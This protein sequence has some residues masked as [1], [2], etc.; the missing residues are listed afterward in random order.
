MA[1]ETGLG[2]K[3]ASCTLW[4][5]ACT[6][7]LFKECY[8]PSIKNETIGRFALFTLTDQAEK[9]DHCAHIYNKSLLYLVSN[10][11]EEKSRIPV[12]RD[13]IPILGMQKFVSK[14][15]DLQSLFKRPNAE[16]VLAPNSNQPGSTDHS[17]CNT[18]G[19]FDDDKA[20]V[21][22][23]LARMLN[24]AKSTTKFVF[25][26]SESSLKDRRNNLGAR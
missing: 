3:I 16:Q 1:G 14:D 26:S 8:L 9:D 25:N 12:V 11:F 4:A 18:H 2:L 24:K 23:T 5:P 17:T 13:G 19:G 20:T 15:K 21:N 6:I 7:E 22:A 10:S